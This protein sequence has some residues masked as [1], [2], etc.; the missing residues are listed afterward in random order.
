M[1]PAGAIFTIGRRQGA[2]G[3]DLTTDNIER[4]EI[5]RGPQ[6]E[7]S[8]TGGHDN[9]LEECGTLAGGTERF[10]GLLGVG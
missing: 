2:G 4:I 6:S 9:T 8:L 7:V 3:I 1:I 5:I 10:R